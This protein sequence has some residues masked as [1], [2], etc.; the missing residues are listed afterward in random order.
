MIIGLLTAM[1]L[2][3]RRYQLARVLIVAEAAF[4]LGAWGLAQYPYI[5][6]PHA[7]IDN[8]ANDPTVISILLVC[9]A[10]GMVILIPS[11]YYLFSVFKLSYPVPGLQKDTT[12][13]EPQE[14][15]RIGTV[16]N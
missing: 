6:P 1:A 3:M 10:I 16:D 7:T 12:P 11:L 5:I 14:Q 9:T 4:M 2:L 15:P 13:K 8:S